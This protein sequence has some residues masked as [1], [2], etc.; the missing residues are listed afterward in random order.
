[1]GIYFLFG[2]VHSK[3]SGGFFLGVPLKINAELLSGIFFFNLFYLYLTLGYIYILDKC[4]VY[5][6]KTALCAHCAVVVN[7]DRGARI[8]RSQ[9]P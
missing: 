6:E 3:Y 9:K 8:F 4:L 1:M 7:S 2:Y 5:C